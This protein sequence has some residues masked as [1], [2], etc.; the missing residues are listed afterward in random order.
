MQ[1][2]LADRLTMR[3]APETAITVKRRASDSPRRLLPAKDDTVAAARQKMEETYRC[4]LQRSTAA[5][6]APGGTSAA[7]LL[8]RR[9]RDIEPV[10]KQRA[11]QRAEEVQ[12]LHLPAVSC[13]EF[14]A[15]VATASTLLVRLGARLDVRL[16]GLVR[17]RPV[18]CAPCN[19]RLPRQARQVTP[20]RIVSSKECSNF[21]PAFSANRLPVQTNSAA[22]R[23]SLLQDLQDVA[24][25]EPQ[26]LLLPTDQ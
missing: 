7:Y 11:E 6:R 10:T 16:G 5:L 17:Q 9:S 22:E 12:L 25:K 18:A 20:S 19:A 23:Q 3:S 24:A 4:D 13:F 8:Y 2:E 26:T 1:G 15:T 21:L 14:V